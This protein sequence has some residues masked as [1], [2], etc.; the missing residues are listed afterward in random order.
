MKN[1]YLILSAACVAVSASA[2]EKQALPSRN[3]VGGQPELV[4]N[5]SNLGDFKAS[6]N[7]KSKKTFGTTRA[8]STAGGY[9]A[10]SSIWAFGTST[11]GYGYNNT[12][13][14]ASSYGNLN[15]FGYASEGAEIEWKYSDLNDYEVEN[16]QPVWNVK[17]SNEQNLSIKSGV[18]LLKT[19]EIT[20]TGSTGS[21]SY[22]AVPVQY[23]CGGSASMWAGADEE[24][25][26]FGVTPYQNFGLKTPQGYTGGL[27][28]VSSYHPGAKGYNAA[29][30]YVDSSDWANWQSQFEEMAGGA[31]VSNLVL[32]NFSMMFPAPQSTYTMTRMWGSMNVTAKADTQ[33]LS[34]IYPIDE[35]GMI[36][37]MPIAL[38][39]AAVKK[40]E[41]RYLMFE[42]NPL[43]EFGDE[44]EGDVFIDS[45]VVMTIEGFV[46]NDA[47]TSIQAVSGYY[48]FNFSDY[49]QLGGVMFPA[50][51]LYM[52]F[53]FDVDGQP[54]TTIEADYGGYVYDQNDDDATTLLAYHQFQIDAVFA[55][56]QSVNGEETVTVA[57][58]GGSVEVELEAY[59]YDIKTL[60]EKGLYEVS[61]PEWLNVEFS[62][63]DMQT[64]TVMM[65]VT[66]QAGEDRTG[67]VEIEGLGATYSLQVNQGEGNAVS[68]V[69]ADK[70]AEYFDLAGRRVAN[71]EKG[72]YIKKTGNKAE[73]VL[74]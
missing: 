58:D 72:I 18:G 33:L 19:P 67:Y 4:E 25:G 12:I 29:G 73:K 54:V 66:A 70:N 74:F 37:E 26:D 48:P 44:I 24:T 20:V 51:T 30:V 23:Y 1:L 64:Q 28:A 69:V 35:D 22:S 34:Y 36:A 38:G 39:Y 43:D 31:E 63:P 50:P 7:L 16:K 53:S 27:T 14:F 3:L 41:N 56:I 52:Q 55:F 57:K 65:T 68:V 47:I 32:D 9:L 60:V 17:T 61:A 15:F 49:K 5:V 8:V 71:P 59:W 40:G 10:G 21:V 62:E 11:E 46:G 45:K 2:A 13:G 42:Y 6:H